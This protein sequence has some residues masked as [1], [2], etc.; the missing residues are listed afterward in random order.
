MNV[1]YLTT[2]TDPVD[3]IVLGSPAE[4]SKCSDINRIMTFLMIKISAHLTRYLRSDVMSK[5]V[6]HQHQTIGLSNPHSE[7][8]FGQT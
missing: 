2:A 6:N 1:L 8:H 7:L 4:L 5:P 3:A